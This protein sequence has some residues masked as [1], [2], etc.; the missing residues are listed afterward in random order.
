MS[1]VPP[2]PDV[3]WSGLTHP[4][5]VRPNNED[6]FLALALDAR[7]VR[8]LGKTG[9]APLAASDFVFAVC[10][11]MGGAKSGEFASRIAVDRITRLL[12]AALSRNTRTAPVD[13]SA[14]LGELVAAIHRD[15]LRLGYSYEECAGMGTTLTLAWVRQ[16]RLHFAHVGDCR[17]YHLP[18]GG[19]LVQLSHDH[20]YPG[21]LRQQGRLNEREARTHPRRNALNQALGASNQ[22]VDP[23]LG[24]LAHRPGDRFLIC[25]DGVIDGL[26]DN[27]LEELLGTDPEPNDPR[28]RAH[29]IVDEAV[30]ASGRDNATAVVFESAAP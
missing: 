28:S 25:S 18:A 22:F 24:E 12:P 15:L 13:F 21:W 30:A 16:D 23:Q 10:D 17:L 27:R 9:R 5:R 4:G 20:S 19:P 6:V 26:W 7:E 14:V 1:Q 2:L 29:R 3:L 8:F 11:G